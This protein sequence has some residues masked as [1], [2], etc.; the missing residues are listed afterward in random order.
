MSNRL[1]DTDDV[2]VLAL[3]PPWQ[4]GTAIDIDG[5][6]VRPQHAHQATGHVL[7]AATD[8]HHTIHPL[9]LH[10]GFHTVRNHLAAH[11]RVLHAF[12]AHGHAVRN[13]RRAEDLGIATCFFDSGNRC[14]SQLLQAA[15]A[16]C[17]GAVAIRHP[18]HGF[19]EIAFGVAHGVIHRAIRC[20]RLALGDV[21][22]ARI[23][24]DGFDV[25]G[26][27]LKKDL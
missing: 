4:D 24:D 9:A 3:V 6:H 25:H 18:D 5:R 26:E 15:V 21:A 2:E 11:Q 20:A 17:D 14:V 13:G 10:A 22:A 19:L 16:R 27:I 12:G 23:E 1:E 8:H 7:V